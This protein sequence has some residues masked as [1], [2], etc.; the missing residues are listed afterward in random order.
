MVTAYF[1]ESRRLSGIP[2]FVLVMEHAFGIGPKAAKFYAADNSG[3]YPTPFPT[4]TTKPEDR[5]NYIIHK[6]VNTYLTGSSLDSMTARY[7]QNL[8]RKVSEAEI[9]D[10]WVD[11]PDFYHFF[12]AYILEAAVRSMYGDYILSLNPTFAEDFRDYDQRM[13]S[14]L[15][16]LPRWMN[17]KA[18][19]A[20]DK[21]IENIKRWHRYSHQHYDVSD[22]KA[23]RDDCEWEPY[24][25]S[26]FGR[27]RQATF[28]KM[29]QMTRLRVLVRT[30]GSYG[31][32]AFPFLPPNRNL[33]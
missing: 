6:M 1:K 9:G 2:G 29:P 16:G 20:R 18:Y 25:G 24:F 27:V 31:G 12:Q 33:D 17:S 32:E 19:A 11:I 26:K 23:E 8:A 5:I 14:L 3:M 21:M 28:M 22:G 4:S 10:E 15:Y 30:W 13:H 7:Q